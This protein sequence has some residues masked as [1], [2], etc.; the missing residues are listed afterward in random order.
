MVAYEI[1]GNNTNHLHLLVLQLLKTLYL[2][3]V[4]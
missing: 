2:F 4:L 3:M 1:V